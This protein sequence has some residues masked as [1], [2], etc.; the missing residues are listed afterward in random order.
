MAKVC[1][2]IFWASVNIA[3]YVTK[4]WKLPYGHI[5]HIKYLVLK[6]SLK[7]WFLLIYGSNAVKMH[8]ITRKSVEICFCGVSK[9]VVNSKILIIL[10]TPIRVIFQNLVTY[11][12]THVVCACPNFLG[13]MSHY[14]VSCLKDRETTEITAQHSFWVAALSRPPDP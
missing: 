10:G 11:S 6:S 2:L 7:I 8:W 13:R 5:L 14:C 12:C 3:T 4:F 1:L 9:T